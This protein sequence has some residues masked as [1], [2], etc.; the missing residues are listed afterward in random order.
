MSKYSLYI[1]PIISILWLT[2]PSCQQSQD[3]AEKLRN[4]I[5]DIHDEVMPETDH[6]LAYKELISQKLELFNIRFNRN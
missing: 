6:I 5:I 2:F 4:D 1:F 3:E